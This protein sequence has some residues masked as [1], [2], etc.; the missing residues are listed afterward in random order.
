M[1]NERIL[2]AWYKPVQALLFMS[3]L[4]IHNLMAK[5]KFCS[6]KTPAITVDNCNKPET[7][8]I[9]PRH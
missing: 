4:T 1:D 9:F 2:C 3:E 5:E 7:T 6:G 8:T